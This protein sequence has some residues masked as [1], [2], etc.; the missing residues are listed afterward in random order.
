MYQT[1]AFFKQLIFCTAL[2]L[3]F[4]QCS[5]EE[6]ISPAAVEQEVINEQT[7]MDESMPVSSISISGTFTSF[8]HDVKCDAC[9]FKIAEGTTTV[10]GQSIKPGTV[11]CLNEKIAYGSLEFVNMEGTEQQPI[12]IGY[13][14]N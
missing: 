8:F 14:N 5:E 4:V 7:E 11:I 1:K 6:L 9:T 3:L 13:C 10:D 2:T 12:T